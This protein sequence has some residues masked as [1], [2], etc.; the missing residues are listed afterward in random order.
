MPMHLVFSRLASHLQLLTIK[1]CVVCYITTTTKTDVRLC[2]IDVNLCQHIT[3]CT[4]PF[5]NYSQIGGW[6]GWVLQ[7]KSFAVS[8]GIKAA[9]PL[10][11]DHSD[12]K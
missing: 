11:H 2:W 1:S 5:S 8:T 7:D 6:E 10:H 3:K 4:N 9:G 12:E